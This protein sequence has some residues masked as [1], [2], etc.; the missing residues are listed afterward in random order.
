MKRSGILIVLV[1]LLAGSFPLPAQ[2]APVAD[3]T[4]LARY[5]PQD[6]V[7]YLGMRTDAAFVEMIDAMVTR[8]YQR[9]PDP[10]GGGS[11]TDALDDWAQFALRDETATFATAIRPWLGDV[12]AAGMPVFRADIADMNRG[13]DK[14]FIV[15]SITDRA[16]AE[17]FAEAHMEALVP[18]LFEKTETAAY[19]LLT[20]PAFPDTIAY[21]ISD[22]AMLVGSPEALPLDGLPQPTLRGNTAFNAALSKLPESDYHLVA[23]VDAPAIAREIAPLVKRAAGRGARA[24]DLTPFLD[25]LGPA[26]LGFTTFESRSLAMDYAQL[27]DDTAALAEM[28]MVLPPPGP[29][30]DL[31]FAARIP[32]EAALV[33]QGAGFGPAVQAMIDSVRGFSA[34]LEASGIAF[35]DL[36]PRAGQAGELLR[37]VRLAD[38][39]TFA[40]LT[41]KG[42][43]GLELEDVLAWMRGDFAAFVTVG[44]EEAGVALNHA[45]VVETTDPKAAQAL[46]EAAAA[47]LEQNAIDHTRETVSGADVIALPGFLD[48]AGRA[49]WQGRRPARAPVLAPQDALIGANEAVFAAGTRDAVAFSLAPSNGGL[50]ED[51]AYLAAQ[52]HLLPGAETIWYVSVESLRAFAEQAAARPRVIRPMR[53]QERALLSLFESAAISSVM[54][55]NGDAIARFTVTL[56]E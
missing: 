44:L 22:D 21:M 42:A 9:A 16:G 38:L 40:E 3:L 56:A 20:V 52:A 34:Y 35:F 37:K 39:A 4:A 1:V 6:A 41:F 2:A 47:F 13:L 51:P 49:F 11:L 48:P 23:Y 18:D 31:R 7:F 29:P 25:A 24:L 15:L 12:A 19:T 46:V 55:D 36:G 32:A 30:V 54:A 8:A 14:A 50:A 43:M 26:A 17:A 33:V 10:L 45:W 27:V 53:A 28:G 5:F